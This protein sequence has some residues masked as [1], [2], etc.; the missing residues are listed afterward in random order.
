MLKTKHLKAGEGANSG[1]TLIE[2]LV[3]IV[4]IG[5]LAT[6]ATVALSSAREKARDAR[7]VSDIKQIMTALE[8]Y[9]SDASS[10]PNTITINSP[11]AYS[12]VTYMAK[13]PGNPSPQS[14]CTATNPG[15][16]GTALSYLY[17]T[18]T[19]TNPTSYTLTYCLKGATGQILA[20]V[21]TAS[22]SGITLR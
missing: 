8:L 16:I 20:G 3:V 21:N 12:G 1:F 4:I 6:L 15:P 7:R 22:Q 11:I 5:V 2:L 13:V 17:Q 18:Y 10:Y 9:Y 19:Q 14:D